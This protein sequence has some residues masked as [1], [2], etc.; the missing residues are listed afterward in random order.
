MLTNESFFL[1]NRDDHA[2]LLLHGLGGG[3][4][5]MQ[6]LGEYL[7]Q[8]GYSVQAFNY[9]GH[10]SELVKMPPSTWQQ[11]Y[12]A[13][14]EKYHKLYLEYGSVS[15]IGFSTGC[16][17]ALNLATHHPLKNIVLLSPF[18][19][20]KKPWYSPFKTEAYLPLLMS[21]LKE[22]PRVKGKNYLGLATFNLE[23]VKSALELIKL[24]KTKLDQV[25]IPTLIIQSPSDSVVDPSGATFLYDNLSSVADKQLSWLERSDHII[26]LDVERERVFQEVK[27]FLDRFS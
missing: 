19:A 6:L 2:C 24:V 26:T 22:V 9:P 25:T 11:W 12:T 4:Y 8:A 20:I 16:P 7:Y 1:Q 27:A 5:E 21:V 13:I 3:S 18:F 23:S 17:L 10:E 15:V 14:E